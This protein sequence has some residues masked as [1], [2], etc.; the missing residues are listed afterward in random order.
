MHTGQQFLTQ[1]PIWI[2]QDYLYTYLHSSFQLSSEN[3]W[4]AINT[5][6]GVNCISPTSCIYRRMYSSLHTAIVQQ[7]VPCSH[8]SPR[9]TFHHEI[10]EC[11]Q[12]KKWDA[13]Y[14][15]WVIL[16]TLK[17]LHIQSTS[18][19]CS[20]GSKNPRVGFQKQMELAYVCN[21]WTMMLLN[22]WDNGSRWCN[23][24]TILPSCKGSVCIIVK[25]EES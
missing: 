3:D 19:W 2:T 23:G 14:M 15:F 12:N 1:I 17:S 10:L 20:D 16:G 4:T 13:Y 7:S 8:N 25:E 18:I 9:R 21:T 22:W 6:S 24:L 11:I 5:N